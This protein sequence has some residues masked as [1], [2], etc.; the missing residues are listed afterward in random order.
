M[1]HMHIFVLRYCHQIFLNGAIDERSFSSPHPE[2]IDSRKPIFMG[3]GVG[4]E[5]GHTKGQN[6]RTIP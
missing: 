3:V 5:I 1:I 6:E 4:G 2:T